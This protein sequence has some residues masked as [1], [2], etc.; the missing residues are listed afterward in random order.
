VV[1][2]LYVRQKIVPMNHHLKNLIS[3]VGEFT[4]AVGNALNPLSNAEVDA[5]EVR[6]NRSLDCV[7]RE[8]LTSF[9]AS[10][11]E[12]DVIF[13]PEAPLP[14]FYSKTNLGIIGIFLGKINDSYPK[15]KNICILHRM[16]IHG[17]D[18]PSDFLPV[19][20]VGSGDIYGIRH[21]GS[22]WL[23]IHD[24]PKG[25]ELNQVYNSFPAW[26]DNLHKR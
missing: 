7:H 13:T 21:D 6:I 26:L 1:R 3:K 11:F 4:P 16:N 15:A 24:A 22:V 23:W 2:A 5:L 17:D 20:D 25:K 18:L 9:G 14:K 19:A 12:D 8:L 10:R